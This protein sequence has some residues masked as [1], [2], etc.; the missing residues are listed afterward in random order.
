[1]CGI[2]ALV[3]TPWQQS[4]ETALRPLACRG[5]DAEHFWRDP[6]AAFG[7]RRLAVIDLAGGAQPMPSEDGRYVIAYN[8][9]IYNFQSVRH[10]LEARGRRFATRSDTEVI[11]LGYAEWGADVVRRLDG[12]FAFAI[13]DTRER[14][15][16]AAR[17]RLGIKPLFYSTHKGLTL[18][19]TLAPF[20][21]LAGFPREL[22]YEALRDYL[23][24]QTPLA[25]HSFLKPVRQLPP[26]HWLEWR[27]GVLRTEGY[28]SI[29]RPAEASGTP[30]LDELD[31]L[32]AQTVKEQLVADVPVGA[33]LSGG[34]DSS[35]VVHYMAQAGARPPLPSSVRSPDEG[36]DESPAALE[37]SRRYATE[38][39]VLEA[40]RIGSAELRGALDALDQPLADPAYVPTF[41]LSRLTRR[42]VT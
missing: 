7:H 20:L 13:W 3:D 2:L 28:W 12:I 34:I 22:D 4:L 36:Y 17:D 8:G 41:E 6:H 21:S 11:L 40:P 32:L 25:P 27:E 18:A 35:L 24:F 9:E 14:R 29:P 16:F 30:Q 37:V 39:H 15:L 5:P 42:H 38:H 10:D 31:A 33:F 23:A 26:A 1:M 19:S